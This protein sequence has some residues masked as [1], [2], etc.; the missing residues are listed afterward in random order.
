MLNSP[1]H[2][3]P[4]SVPLYVFTSLASLLVAAAIGKWT[5]P[6]PLVT[7]NIGSYTCALLMLGALTFGARAIYY[8]VH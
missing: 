3:F 2:R 1:K 5:M 6:F 7:E 8:Q 4:A